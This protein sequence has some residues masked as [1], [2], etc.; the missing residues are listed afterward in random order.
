[1]INAEVH[2]LTADAV[3]DT[4]RA[5]LGLT[6]A[7]AISDFFNRYADDFLGCPIA[8]VLGRGVSMWCGVWSFKTARRSR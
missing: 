2:G 1:M 5:V 6:S 7:Q 4:E 8:G 3:T